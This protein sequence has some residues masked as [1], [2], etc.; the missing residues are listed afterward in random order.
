[1]IRLGTAAIVALHL[2]LLAASLGD[3]RVSVDSAYHVALARQ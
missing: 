2:A 1:V 3:Y